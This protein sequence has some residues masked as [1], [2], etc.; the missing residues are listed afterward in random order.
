MNKGEKK[1]ALLVTKDQWENNNG[2]NL[3]EKKKK[4]TK[5]IAYFLKKD[6]GK[7]SSLCHH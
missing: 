2:S 6:I 4:K 1:S 7:H 5:I 3:N